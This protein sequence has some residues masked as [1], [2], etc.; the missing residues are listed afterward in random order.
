MGNPGDT[1]SSGSGALPVVSG[2]LWPG[3]QGTTDQSKFLEWL[4]TELVW[5]EDWRPLRPAKDREWH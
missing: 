4:Y 2:G 5:E 1:N 3:Q